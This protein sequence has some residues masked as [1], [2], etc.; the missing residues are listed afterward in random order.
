MYKTEF[1]NPKHDL[2][3][4]SQD[5]SCS[6]LPPRFCSPP[7]PAPASFEGWPWPWQAMCSALVPMAFS[8]SRQNRAPLLTASVAPTALCWAH[9]LTS[10][11]PRW[12]VTP[13]RMGSHHFGVTAL[14]P[15]QAREQTSEV[16]V[17]E[18]DLSLSEM[19]SYG[20]WGMNTTSQPASTLLCFWWGN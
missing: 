20:F 18:C 5:G 6:L 7:P 17:C 13:L 9:L 8:A 14:V 15:N 10:L 11:S 12:P 3:S 4:P 2:S 1:R 16:T 19:R